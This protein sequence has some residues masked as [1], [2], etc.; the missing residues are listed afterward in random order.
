MG[1]PGGG[2]VFYFAFICFSQQTNTTKNYTTNLVTPLF[3]PKGDSTDKFAVTSY[4]DKITYVKLQN[5]K[6]GC[7]N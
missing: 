7:L 2:N 3:F 6:S 5:A 4:Q 1:V